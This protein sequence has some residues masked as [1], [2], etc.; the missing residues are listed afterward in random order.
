[1]RNVVNAR[2]ALM[3]GLLTG[4]FLAGCQTPGPQKTDAAAVA[5]ATCPD[6]MQG[7]VTVAASAVPLAVPPELAAGPGST[8]H[9]SLVARRVI[10]SVA[11]KA[12]ARGVR[13]FSSTLTMTPVGGT[14]TGWG[15]IDRGLERS[16][17]LD[18]DPGQL[19]I[20]PFLTSATV[21]AQ[22]M[23]MDVLVSPGGAALDELAITTSPLWSSVQH[24]TRP[25]ELQI[26]FTPVR[27]MTVLDVVNARITLNVTAARA[28]PTGELWRCTFENR[29]ELVDHQSVLPNLW[30]LRKTGHDDEEDQWLALNDPTTGPFRAV[31]LNP[32]A[33]RGFADWLRA[34]GA[35][36][37]DKYLLGL[38]QLEEP[39][40]DTPPAANRAIAVP[41]H[42]IST[43]ELQTLEVKRLG[44]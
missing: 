10:I 11:P 9:P 44:E 42:G 28:R 7:Q 24:P 2:L 27:H 3:L 22:T 6:E 15:T 5:G 41:F 26:T 32:E 8:E 25:D 34:A 18:I 17:A 16:K 29:F 43:E 33:A 20:E 38:F 36:R 12:A 21:Q 37:V 1:M 40:V 4:A 39:D 13:L 31:F 30:G 35:A 19:R 23:T 14:F